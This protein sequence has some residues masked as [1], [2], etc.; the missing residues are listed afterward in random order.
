MP[1]EVTSANSPTILGR[2]VKPGKRLSA[3]ACSLV[4]NYNR[5]GC[6]KEMENPVQRV[7]CADVDLLRLGIKALKTRFLTILTVEVEQHGI[8]SL[9]SYPAGESGDYGGLPDAS[10]TALSE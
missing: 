9:A 10:F 7:R 8:E 4:S 1:I 5:T 2:P 6:F 3:R